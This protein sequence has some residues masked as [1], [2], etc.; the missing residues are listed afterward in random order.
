MTSPASSGARIRSAVAAADRARRIRDAW[1]RATAAAPFVALAAAVG[2][3]TARIAGAS[4]I[5]AVLSLVTPVAVLIAVVAVASRARP[6]A[7]R[8]AACADRDADLGGE[9]RS[10]YW[11]A[12][13]PAADDWAAWHMDHAATV[14]DEVA[15]PSIYPRPAFRV[16]MAV[17]VLLLIAALVVPVPH[18]LYL[19]EAS[20]PDAATV[21]A[22]DLGLSA[23]PPE[24]QR[25]VI[26]AAAAVFAQRVSAGDAL[27]GLEQ[28]TDWR[29]LDADTRRRVDRALRQ[30]AL[31][32][33]AAAGKPAPDVPGRTAEEAQWA[34]EDLAARLATEQAQKNADPVTSAVSEQKS[35]DQAGATEESSDGQGG[36]GSLFKSNQVQREVPDGKGDSSGAAIDPTG[37]ASGEAGTGFGGKHGDPTYRRG[38]EAAI[39]AAFKREV[40]E[41]SENVGS[42][43]HPDERR[44]QTERSASALDYART[45][46]R[47]SY[48]RS[49][50]DA[51]GAVPEARLPW[52][53]RYF[54][55]TEQR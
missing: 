27:A 41:A 14:A 38:Q 35:K 37:P 25:L 52:L 43:D 7:D 24:L 22:N 40:L 29:A 1:V 47:T 3:L 50:V 15:W 49:N 36:E 9:L 28:S 13:R 11:F 51:A 34:K 12:S 46:G 48:D 5:W 6:M 23:A 19:T 32:R 30:I 33:Q 54:S 4:P 2:C 45:P 53:E 8:T 26:D 16:S 10:A 42:N 18:A 21:L 17:S 55:R 31:D 39:A 44:R 20:S